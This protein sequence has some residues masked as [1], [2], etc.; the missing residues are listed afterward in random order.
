[1]AICR[2]GA[3]HRGE[4]HGAEGAELDIVFACPYDFDG[5]AH[6]FGELCGFAGE[7]RQ[8]ASAKAAAYEL[9]M[10]GYVFAWD[11][12]Y[13]GQLIHDD[14][15]ALHGGPQVAFVAVL[16]VS[17]TVHGFHGRVSEDRCF[18]KCFEGMGRGSHGGVEVALV[19]FDRE[20]FGF[21]EVPELLFKGGGVKGVETLVVPGD[22]EGFTALECR[23]IRVRDHRD[24]FVVVFADHP[25]GFECADN[26]FYL[27][28]GGIIVADELA[29]EDRAVFHR[30]VD[31]AGDFRVDAVYGATGDLEGDIE[32]GHRLAEDLEVLRVF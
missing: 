1:L 6:R 26:S 11:A 3:A 4:G 10:W 25:L 28:G 17:E 16:P 5:F 19:V 30:S 8:Q 14:A 27:Q 18:I 23:P 15:G 29:A 21:G 2:D 13:A 9:D 32:P 24:S 12:Q 31:H 7:V 22:V 20:A